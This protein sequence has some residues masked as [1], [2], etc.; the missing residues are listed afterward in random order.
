VWRANR[1][2]NFAA[3]DLGIVPATLAVLL[4]DQW[5][6]NYWACAAAGLTAAVVLGV[7]AEG[8]I[9]RRFFEAPRVLLTVATIGLAQLLGFGALIMPRAWGASPSVRSLPEPFQASIEVGGTVFDGSD[10]IALVVVPVMLVGLVLSLNRTS[11]GV[12][13]RASADRSIRALSLGIPV[14]RLHSLIWTLV[15]VGAFMAL[16]LTAGTG[17]LG[18]GYGTSLGL[19]LRAIAALVLGR[20]THLG[21]IVFS[22]VVLGALEL[23][24]R[25][26]TGDGALV[27]PLLALII[28]GA[29]LVQRKGISRAARDDTSSWTLAS[30]VRPVP[31]ELASCWEVRAVR[32]SLVAVGALA[33]AVFPLVL[34]TGAM[35]KLGAVLIVASVGV[36]LVILSGW[37]GQLSLGQMAFAGMGG[38]V[39]AWATQ[40]RSIDP[41]LAIGLGA[42][43]GAAIAVVVGLPALRIRGMYLAVT[44][45]AL[46]LAFSNGVLDNGYVDWIPTASFAGDRPP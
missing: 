37:A 11:L 43:A 6:W 34:S 9:V 8:L 5:G 38:A 24:V 3:G 12:A 2:I 15:T 39:F 44:T 41:L 23:A 42:L 26:Q 7:A 10:M 1:V 32:V 29:L 33:L 13:V 18:V 4:A 30:D 16:F 17:G 19:V 45:L 36:S 14:K 46:A 21:V 22:S 28:V 40:D 20:M 31:P 25:F 35:L 27:S